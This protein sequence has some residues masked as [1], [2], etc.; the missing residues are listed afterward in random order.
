M[1][2]E[3]RNLVELQK[4]DTRIRVLKEDIESIDER[5][6]KLEEEFEK[7]ASSIRE[8]QQN[9]DDAQS[10]RT[11]LDAEIAEAK[12]KLE[13]ANRNLKSAADQKQYEAAM[14]EVDTL[15]RQISKFETSILENMESSDAA[16]KVLEE[17]SDEVENLESDWKKK[18]EKFNSEFTKDKKELKKLE[19]E[20]GN[21]LGK[22]TPRLAAVYDRL[23]ARSRD[24]IAVAEVIDDACSSCFMKLRKQMLVDLKTTDEVMTCESCTRILYLPE[25]EAEASAS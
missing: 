14:R 12:N 16:T 17:R 10:K 24:G 15:E 2:S 8:I 6:A 23:I 7:H 4:T 3:L 13:R 22:V 21:V 11:E 25:E 9:R 1:N 20:R 19:S 5:R 18:Q